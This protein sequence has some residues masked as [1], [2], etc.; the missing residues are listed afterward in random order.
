MH[1]EHVVAT[2]AGHELVHQQNE[3][4]RR[5]VHTSEEAVTLSIG[6]THARP[7]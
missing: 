6:H 1:V 3:L 5:R 4:I 7:L 2:G